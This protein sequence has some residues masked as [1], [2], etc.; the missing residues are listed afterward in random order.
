MGVTAPD[1]L[2]WLRAGTG[3]TCDYNGDTT[4]AYFMFARKFLPNSL[5]RFL[6]F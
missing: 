1:F 5:T 4:T 2:R 6:I 3:T